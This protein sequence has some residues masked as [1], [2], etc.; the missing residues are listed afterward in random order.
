MS[1]E[2][3]SLMAFPVICRLLSL[4]KRDAVSFMA[5]D[6]SKAAFDNGMDG[7][8]LSFRIKVVSL[9]ELYLKCGRQIEKENDE[10]SEGGEVS[11][12]RLTAKGY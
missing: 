6:H 12:G 8:S 11:M 3:Q 4:E 7:I 5:G 9:G 10:T 1:I 2:D